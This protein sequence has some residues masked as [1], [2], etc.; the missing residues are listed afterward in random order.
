M[1]PDSQAMNLSRPAASMEGGGGGKQGPA[2][3]HAQ[4]AG[5]YF[6]PQAVVPRG[7]TLCSWGYA[8]PKLFPWNLPHSQ[9][10]TPPPVRRP[11][12]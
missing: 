11:V 2:L 5:D 10:R 8:G 12:L 4:R 7:V 9:L 1:K 3:A 6:S